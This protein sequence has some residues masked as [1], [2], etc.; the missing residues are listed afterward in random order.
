MDGDE[1]Y[2]MRELQQDAEN[3][4]KSARR[5]APVPVA[6]LMSQLLSRRGYVQTLSNEQLNEAWAAAV[7]PD[8]AARTR[9]GKLRGGVLEI[10]TLDSPLIQEL[11]FRKRELIQK[12]GELLPESKIRDLRL[13]VGDVS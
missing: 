6:E 3:K 12:L 10:Y 2:G 9:P 13:R 7:G 5:V 11:T 4:Q 8:G 1:Q